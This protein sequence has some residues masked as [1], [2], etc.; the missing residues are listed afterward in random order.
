[1]NITAKKKNDTKKKV[2]VQTGGRRIRFTLK[3]DD[4]IRSA[5][6][7]AEASGK[8]VDKRALARKINR[9]SGSVYNRI[10]KFSRS[11]PLKKKNVFS[12]V[13]DQCILETLVVPRLGTEKLAEVFL[14]QNDSEVVNLSKQWNRGPT[15]LMNRWMNIL[16][17]MLLQHYSGTLNL[18]VER[19]LA[20][21]ISENYKHFAEI[22][23]TDVAARGEFAGHTERSLR[24]MYFFISKHTR[25]RFEVQNSEV[26]P[27]QIAQYCE[28]VYVEG[29]RKLTVSNS[30][31]QRQNEVI[32]FFKDKVLVQSIKDFL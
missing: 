13:E 19:M 10:A 4:I 27:Q 22:D 11:Q 30:K 20:N 18:R 21:R 25:L 29:G 7:E 12:L 6:I 23:W 1:M 15:S 24:N 8:P 5:M 31:V 14:R 16:Q 17:P 2:N 26:N 9:S 32:A 3:E 28:E